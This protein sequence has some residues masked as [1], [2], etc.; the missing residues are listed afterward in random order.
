M[1]SNEYF[2]FVFV[3]AFVSPLATRHSPLYL[4]MPHLCVIPAGIAQRRQLAEYISSYSQRGYSYAS[5]VDAKAG[6]S[7]SDVREVSW[8]SVLAASRSGGLFAEKQLFVIESAESLGEFPEE[9]EQYLDSAAKA[10]SVVV[11]VYAAEGKGGGAAKV[12]PQSALSKIEFAAKEEAV[13]PWKRKDWVIRLSKELGVSISYEAAALLAESIDEQEELRGELVKLADYSRP[14]QISL[15]LVRQLSFD[16]GG[17]SMLKF[18]D[19]FS[20]GKAEDVI[21][22]LKYLKQDAS[23]LPMITALSNRLRPALYITLYKDEQAA[24]AALGVR[25][26]AARMAKQALKIYGKPAIQKFMLELTRLS[27]MEKTNYAEGWVGFETAL[28]LFLCY[29]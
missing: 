18:L 20:Q 17:S 4:D 25:D 13:P 6:A 12:F 3:F 29:S 7:S 1:G 5:R 14:R 23:P 19:G 26:Y 27:Y 2:A 16:E 22:S 9:L 8:S 11:C 10:D 28:C 21:S 15:E 24:L